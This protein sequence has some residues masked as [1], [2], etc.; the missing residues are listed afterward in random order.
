MPITS[1]LAALMRCPKLGQD[2]LTG[3]VGGRVSFWSCG[4]TLAHRV[5]IRRVRRSPWQGVGRG[6][7]CAGTGR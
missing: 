5:S 4:G 2:C 6:R 1:C 3:Q 7:A